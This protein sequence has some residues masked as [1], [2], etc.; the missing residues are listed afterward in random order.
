[1]KKLG[2]VL[3]GVA[4]VAGMGGCFTPFRMQYQLTISSTEGGKVTTPGEGIFTYWEGTTVN[5]VAEAEEGYFFANWTGN[6][7]TIGNVTSA[8][9]N[10][11]MNCDYS[12]TANFAP[13]M[14]IWDWYD[15][16]AV[17]NDL[18]S[19]YILT[20]DL[21]STTAGYEE[22]ASP[23]ANEGEGWQP[24]GTF[25]GSF[26]GQGYEIRDLFINRPGEIYVGLCGYVAAG[27]VIENVGVVNTDMTG[28]GN[29]GNL[30]GWNVGTISNSY[31]TGSVTGNWSV[32][33]LVGVNGEGTVS[34]SY[35]TGSV[36]S[37]SAVGGLVGWN[38]GGTVSNSYST[39][40][41]SGDVGVGGLVGYNE[42]GTASNSFWDI[43]TS[44]QATSD[45][46]TGMNTTEMKDITTFT[47]AGWDITVVDDPDDRD[48]DYIWNIVDHETCPFLRWEP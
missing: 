27:G 15:L 44:G 7:S 37:H 16:D 1:M 2:L 36:T 35:A 32:G 43:E 19:A 33:G 45:G 25:T 21:D 23:T 30:V 29:V 6:V 42:E 47:G 10:I 4:L 17:R 31:S 41:V 18:G 14:E 46:G 22:L 34:N 9:T 40:S 13:V 8:T 11:T 28:Q 48:T 38:V 5:L 26:D 3:L 24:I 12:V 39:G 20:N